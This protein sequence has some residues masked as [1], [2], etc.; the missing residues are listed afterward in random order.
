MTSPYTTQPVEAFMAAQTAV[1]LVLGAGAWALG[2]HTNN[3]QYANAGRK[4]VLASGAA[5][6]IIG[7]A[8]TMVNFLFQTGHGI[9]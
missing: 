6:M 2:S 8:P 5:A 1:G 3:Y 4:A 7:A 9:H